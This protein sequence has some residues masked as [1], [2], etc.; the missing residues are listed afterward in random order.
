M[1]KDILVK[2]QKCGKGVRKSTSSITDTDLQL[3]G[4]YFNIDH[5]TTPSTRVLKH[6]I[7]FYIIYYLYCNCQEHLEE[8]IKD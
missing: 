1:F 3:I 2:A 7:M 4:V 8:M 5:L 6:T